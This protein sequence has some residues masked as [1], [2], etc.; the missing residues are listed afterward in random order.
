ML[1][2]LLPVGKIDVE[3]FGVRVQLFPKAELGTWFFRASPPHSSRLI[4]K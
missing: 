2:A 1:L 4:N 3:S